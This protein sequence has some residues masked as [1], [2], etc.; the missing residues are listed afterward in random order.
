MKIELTPEQ[1]GAILS[2][3]RLLEFKMEADLERHAN[4]FVQRNLNNVLET[5]KIIEAAAYPMFKQ[6][7][8][9]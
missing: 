8:E 6:H 2:G 7:D 9:Q 5:I 3:L 4:E 1:T